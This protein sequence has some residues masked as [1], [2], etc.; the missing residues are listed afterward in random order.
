MTLFNPWKRTCAIF[1]FCSA[2]TIG[3]PAQTFTKLLDFK[4]TNGAGPLSLVQGRYGHLYG[5]TASGGNSR[6]S[7]YEGCG[8]I[9]RITAG[10]LTTLY[11]FCPQKN[12]VDGANPSAGLV[13]AAD[14][15][16]YGT[17]IQGVDLGGRRIIKKKNVFKITTQ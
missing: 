12:C 17:T 3:A 7:C 6:S 9:F 11:S 10:A 15:D 14:G 16:F 2:T 1:L 8:T 4:G 13:L 5:V